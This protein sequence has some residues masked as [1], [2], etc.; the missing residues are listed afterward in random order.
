M[1]HKG[2]TKNIHK[3]KK[4]NT[5]CEMER[6]PHT[7]QQGI[8]QMDTTPNTPT[9]HKKKGEMALDV[10][11][12]SQ[13]RLPPPPPPPLARDLIRFDIPIFR[14]IYRT[15]CHGR[16]F[17]EGC[18]LA[19]HCIRNISACLRKACEE[20]RGFVAFTGVPI[21]SSDTTFLL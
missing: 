9:Q 18:T 14:G 11:Y 10:L 1:T 5:A 17:P 13:P 8:S 7:T 15:V 21:E 19:A 4:K 2:C 6:G 20:T 12:L 3:R 16:I